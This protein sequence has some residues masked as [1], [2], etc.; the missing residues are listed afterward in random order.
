LRKTS[1]PVSDIRISPENFAELTLYLAEDKISNL[2]AKR[3]LEEMFR[4]GDNPSDIINRLG[5]WQLSEAGDLEDI[6]RHIIEENP[7]AVE[8]YRKGK[9]ASLQFL[10]GQVMKDS[11]GK[12]NP[13]IIQEVIKKF[14]D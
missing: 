3:V 7:K 10:I 8:D 1:A 6:A 11:R 13:K 5:L 4:S 14:L 2:A 9:A 12:A